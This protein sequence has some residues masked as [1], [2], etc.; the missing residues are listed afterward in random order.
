MQ[1]DSHFRPPPGTESTGSHSYTYQYGDDGVPMHPGLSV[2]D[3]RHFQ[4][5]LS[6]NPRSYRAHVAF[7]ITVSV[8]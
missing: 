7:R 6:Q 8:F 3:E 4:F 1:I 2:P 5:A